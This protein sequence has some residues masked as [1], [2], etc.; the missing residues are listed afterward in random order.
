MPKDAARLEGNR[1]YRAFAFLSIEGKETLLSVLT[2]QNPR[3]TSLIP[4]S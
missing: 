4:P 3:R 1:R 2:R